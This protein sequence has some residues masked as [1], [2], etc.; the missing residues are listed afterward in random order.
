MTRRHNPNPN[1]NPKTINRK[2]LARRIAEYKGYKKG[3]VEELL[4]AY[5]DVVAD[6]LENGEEVK[7]GK[8]FKII[9]QKM[10][11]KRAWDGLNRKYFIRPAKRVPKV[12]PLSRLQEI[13]LPLEG[14]E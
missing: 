9:L 2:E 3:D 11:E 14:E 7:Q 5:E 12:K 10:P 6:A 1:P 4:K 13:E 8:L